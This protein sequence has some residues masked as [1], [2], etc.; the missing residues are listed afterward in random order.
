MSKLWLR[1]HNR[2]EMPQSQEITTTLSAGGRVVIPAKYRKALGVRTGDKV[3]LRLEDGQLRL[4]TRAQ[5]RKL[6][7]DHVCRVVP[8]DVSLAEELIR[9]RR[10][11]ASHE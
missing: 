11:E 7:Q 9:D 8:S 10:R 4:Y 1:C 6:A 5:A 3:V 2:P